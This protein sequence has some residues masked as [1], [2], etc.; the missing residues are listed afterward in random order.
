MIWRRKWQPTP[1]FLPGKSHGERCLA[2]YSPWGC[3]E[4]DMTKQLSMHASDYPSLQKQRPFPPSFLAFFYLRV[5]L[6]CS[7]ISHT[8]RPRGL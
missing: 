5:S 7:V 3:K 2:G 6:S 8:L 1:V 4:M